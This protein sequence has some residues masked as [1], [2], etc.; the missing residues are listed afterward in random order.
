MENEPLVSIIVP[1]RNNAATI[2]KCLESI[3]GQTYPDIEVIVVDNYSTDGTGE[4][5]EGLGAKLLLK[6]PERSPQ[7]NFGA[8]QASGEYLLF[9]DS[10][11]ELT[12]EVVAECVATARREGAQ[13]VII[14]EV[15]FGEG[16][17]ARCK[18][19]ERSCYNREETM[20]L[21]RFF[22][23]EAFHRVDGFD[24]RMVGFEDRDLHFRIR[25]GGGR[26]RRVDAPIRHNEGRARIPDLVRKKYRYGKNLHL[27]LRKHRGGGNMRWLFLRVTFIKHWGKFARHP[28]LALGMAFMQLCEFAAAGGGYIVS[29]V[30]PGSS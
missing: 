24:E 9:I 19:L 16:F 14:P 7:R 27:Y 28:V 26:V 20:A 4:I 1:T 23:R 12:P 8:E 18:A 13:A 25:E 15:S 10:D 2:S 22:D 29:R 6:G 21:A 5:A 30:R 11:M 3:R 17:W